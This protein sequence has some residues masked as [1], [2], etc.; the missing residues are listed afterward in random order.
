MVTVEN[1]LEWSTIGMALL[2]PDQWDEVVR[3]VPTDQIFQPGKNRGLYNILLESHRNGETIS[4]AIL[5]ERA[6]AQ[7]VIKTAVEQGEVILICEDI[8][9]ARPL[10]S[11][12]EHLARTYQYRMMANS[13]C[14]LQDSVKDQIVSPKEIIA[15]VE[16]ELLKITSLNPARRKQLTE[17]I[18]EKLERLIAPSQGQSE[19]RIKTRLTGLNALIGGLYRGEMC[20]V[21]AQP[22]MGKTSFCLDICMFNLNYGLKTLYISRDQ[23]TEDLAIRVLTAKTGISK[24]DMTGALSP[25]QQEV[26]FAAAT[27]LRV[28]SEDFQV[29]DTPMTVHEVGTECRRMKRQM[30]LDIVIV[31]YITLLTHHKE[32]E[33]QNLW[34]AEVSAYLKDLAKELDVVMVVVS[35]LNRSRTSAHVDAKR[36]MYGLPSMSMLRD[37]GS[38]EQ[39][40]NV[41]LL[42]HIPREI[43]KDLYGEGSP[44]FDAAIRESNGQLEDQAFIVVA[45]NKDGSKGHV[46]VRF[47][48]STG[49]F[50]DKARG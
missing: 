41:I 3:I 22:S 19:A 16:S 49:T 12:C 40:A 7:G 24:G 21:G 48:Y 17:G 15:E 27:K 8:P 46:E 45:K 35:Q 6:K 2:D 5:A 38:L 34:V 47:D 30:G 32:S 29:I 28:A 50:K 25:D 42:P 9:S 44:A 10:F 13:F 43:L 20:I 14:R 31:D 33:N 4:P 23:Q 18:Q 11:Q 26:L 39:D 1:S 37:S 36:Q